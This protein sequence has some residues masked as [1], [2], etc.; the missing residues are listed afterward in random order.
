MGKVDSIIG[1]LIPVLFLFNI[2]YLGKNGLTTDT[3]SLDL[4]HMPSNSTEIKM[5]AK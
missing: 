2:L 1:L 5:M 3:A 4:V